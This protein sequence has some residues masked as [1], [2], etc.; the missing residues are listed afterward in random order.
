M[1]LC[2]L[3]M[4]VTLVAIGASAEDQDT[5]VQLGWSKYRA[6]DF[7]GA[8]RAFSA[9]G[10]SDEAA[11]GLGYVDLQVRGVIAAVALF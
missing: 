2:A 10:A 3:L 7:A 6:G 1:R 8:E 11:V 9:A 4:T 5:Q